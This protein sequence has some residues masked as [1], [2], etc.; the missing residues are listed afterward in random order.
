MHHPEGDGVVRWGWGRGGGEDDG[1]GLDI[2]VLQEM[3]YSEAQT[4]LWRQTR[5]CSKPATFPIS[6]VC[7]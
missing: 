5:E 1:M 2:R 3:G 7:V 4:S 6:K